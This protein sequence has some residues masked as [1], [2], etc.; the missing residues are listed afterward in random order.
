MK[1]KLRKGT[2]Q[3]LNLYYIKNFQT[4]GTA[5]YCYYPIDNI[6]PGSDAWFL[7]GCT[8]NHDVI[9]GTPNSYEYNLG[10]V[11]V[12]EVGHW[13]GLKHTFEGGCDDADGMP[14]TPAE[15]SAA[16]GCPTGRD[17]CPDKEGLDPV[18]NHMDYTYE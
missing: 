2:Y 16:F 5:G 4:S 10:R 11:T 18:H 17:T 15:A 7:D 14:D 3:D 1:K 13:L 12:H 6:V 8:M 9:Y